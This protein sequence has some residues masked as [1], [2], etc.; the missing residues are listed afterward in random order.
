MKGVVVSGGP[1]RESAG[2]MVHVGVAFRVA[3][4]AQSALQTALL[5]LIPNQYFLL[6]WAH[7]CLRL[8]LSFGLFFIKFTLISLP[9]FPH[10]PSQFAHRCHDSVYR[11]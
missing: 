1:G 2:S 7:L 8:C 11:S 6:L 10:S 4:A 3:P 5:I 9:R